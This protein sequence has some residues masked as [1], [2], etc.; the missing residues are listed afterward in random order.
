MR[1]SE[2]EVLSR[3]CGIGKDNGQF[4]TGFRNECL[5]DV[6]HKYYFCQ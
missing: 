3:V 2:D 4:L 6:S 5:Q 1:V